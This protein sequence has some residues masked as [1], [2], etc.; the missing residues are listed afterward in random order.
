MDH[1]E[2]NSSLNDLDARLDSIASG[3]LNLAK[4]KS[5]LKE[6]DEKLTKEEVWS[7]LDL[8]QKLNNAY[9]RFCY[10]E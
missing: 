6:I 1:T 4:K 7:D 9:L 8:S 10:S 2:L 5:K 3:P